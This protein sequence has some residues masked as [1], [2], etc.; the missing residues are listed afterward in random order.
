MSVNYSFFS[1]AYYRIKMPVF[2][3]LILTLFIELGARADVFH[4]IPI[5]RGDCVWAPNNTNTCAEMVQD[6]YQKMI[7]RRILFLGDSTMGRLFQNM[8]RYGGK[9]IKTKRCDW[10][11]NFGLKKS[12]KWIV[13][14][15][16]A[17]PVAYGLTDYWCTDCSGCYS[18]FYTDKGRTNSYIAVEFAK[19]V[20]MQ[21]EVGNTT[22]ESL[23]FFLKTQPKNDL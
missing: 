10:L 15:K 18:S 14:P 19:D 17:G 12:K 4:H 9:V 7:D 13:P 2:L 11:E 3:F 8:H 1:S 5:T 20:E 22:Q 21:S 6:I 16:D 23:V